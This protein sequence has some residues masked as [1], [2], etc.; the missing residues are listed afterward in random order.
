MLEGA[1]VGIDLGTS[2]S[3]VGIWQNDR[4]EIIPNKEGKR[5]TASCVAFAGTEMTVGDVAKFYSPMNASNTIFDVKQKAEQIKK[6]SY[7]TNL[8]S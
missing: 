1:S 3:C 6:K 4:V 2:Y 8:M 5:T 7:L